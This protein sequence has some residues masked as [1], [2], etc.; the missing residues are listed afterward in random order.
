[1]LISCEYAWLPEG[2][3]KEVTVEVQD[4]RIAAIG[5]GNGGERREGLTLPGF[6]NAHS[7]AFHRA[8]RGRT[9]KDK[10]SFW[11]WRDQMYHVAGKLDPDS[12]YRLARAVY[13]E[14][15]L[16]GVTTVG[17]FHY[18]HHGPGGVHYDD[19]NAMGHALIRA[20]KDA[21]IR[22]T[23]IDTLYLTSSVDGAPLEGVTVAE[24]VG[25]D[26]PVRSGAGQADHGDHEQLHDGHP[27]DLAGLG[28]RAQ[29][30]DVERV[31]HRR[32][33][34][35]V[36]PYPTEKPLSVRTPSPTIASTTA[37]QVSTPMRERRIRAA[38]TG[39]ATTYI[40]VMKPETLAGV[41]ASPAVCRIWAT[42]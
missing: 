40:P 29:P 33:E 3:E 10:G 9:H 11:T 21:G 8:L 15:A 23:L 27:Q 41:L 4:G 39:V 5:S 17:E 25:Q 24:P 13:A 12:Y 2:V 31:D 36:S 38:K 18:L 35:Q 28:P 19:P 37:T 32:D 6:A 7:H 26:D 22:V 42:P 20:A 14:M 30:D 16:A 1:M 34:D